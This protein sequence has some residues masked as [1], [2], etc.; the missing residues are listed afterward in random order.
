VEAHLRQ[1]LAPQVAFADAVREAIP[2]DGIYVDELT[3]VAYVGR[4][5]TPFSRPRSFIDSGYQ[6]TL[7]FGFPT[8]LGVKVA[9]P[10]RPV[11][12]VSGD[13]GFMY[14]MPELATAVMHGIAVVAVVFTDSAFGNVKRIQRLD[15]GGKV[16]A[17]E[18]HNPDFAKLATLFGAA[19]VRATTP[20][21]LKTEIRAAIKRPGPT[22]IEVPVG[23]MPD[24]WRL[25]HM[26]R[27]RPKS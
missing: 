5:I 8:A 12:S 24:P 25:V 22:L 9:F 16:I 21:E 7:G 14:A 26:G 11:I 15:Y 19:G 13:G 18:L 20:T 23:E 1:E 2:E 3:Q 10:G 4:V 17:S 27:A 6:G